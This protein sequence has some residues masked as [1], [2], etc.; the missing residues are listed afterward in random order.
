MGFLD[1]ITGKITDAIQLGQGNEDLAGSG[2]AGT[3]SILDVTPT[4]RT[5]GLTSVDGYS[6]DSASGILRVHA[7]IT[8][9][10]RDP[11]EVTHDTTQ[12]PPVGTDV[13]CFVDPDDEQRVHYEVSAADSIMATADPTTTDALRDSLSRML[14]RPVD[15]TPADLQATMQEA[16]SLDDATKQRNWLDSQSS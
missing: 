9:P 13:P 11:Y 6:K 4:G 2:L 8:L 15:D 14:G 16:A 3:A 10:G 7:R 12:E 5:I 1:K